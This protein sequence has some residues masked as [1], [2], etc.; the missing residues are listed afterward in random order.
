MK[1]CWTCQPIVDFEGTRVGVARCEKC[2]ER[3]ENQPAPDEWE[4]PL[5][6]AS[7][8]AKRGAM[9]DATFC[10][11]PFPVS[12][13]RPLKTMTAAEA[14]NDYGVDVSKW[15][16]QT[17][18]DFITLKPT[19]A[20]ERRPDITETRKMDELK[21]ALEQLE[22]AANDW[23]ACRSGTGP[24]REW[25]RKNGSQHSP[26]AWLCVAVRRVKLARGKQ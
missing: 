22:T 2:R 5:W 10:G 11:I 17:H 8:A 14:L 20:R 15:L 26:E 18:L 7:R 3:Q 9:L 4:P 12:R 21:Q 23:A 25:E 1:R 6:R 24:L 16:H 19:P 13:I